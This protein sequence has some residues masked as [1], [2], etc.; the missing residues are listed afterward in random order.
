MHKL[1]HQSVHHEFT[2]WLLVVTY[3]PYR[4]T[5]N[6]IVRRQSLMLF[7]LAGAGFGGQPFTPAFYYNRLGARQYLVYGIH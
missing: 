6:Q 4:L 2:V 3:E 1:L 7:P 5:A